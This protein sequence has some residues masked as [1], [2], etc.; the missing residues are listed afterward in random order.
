MQRRSS[1]GTTRK[2]NGGSRRHNH[3]TNFKEH[4]EEEIQK[5]VVSLKEKTY[6]PQPVRRVYIPK[7]NGKNGP[8]G[9]P[10][11]RDRIVQEALRA[12]LDPIY[13]TDFQAALVWLPQRSLHDGRHSGH[14]ASIQ[15]E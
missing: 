6:E 14:Y 11:L 2:L 9:I 7:S 13:E 4:Y 15:H 1:P 12:I 8:L 5:L 3:G 10:A